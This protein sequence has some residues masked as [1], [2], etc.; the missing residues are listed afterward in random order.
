MPIVGGKYITTGSGDQFIATPFRPDIVLLLFNNNAVQDTWEALPGCL[1]MGFVHKPI[2]PDIS[3][4]DWAQGYPGSISAQEEWSGNSGASSYLWDVAAWMRTGTSTGA[5]LYGLDLSDTGFTLRYSGGFDGGAGNPLYWL[6]IGDEDLNITKTYWDNS[7]ADF[8]CGFE[9]TFLLG[10]GSGSIGGGV[11]SITF[12]DY[13]IATWGLA[14]FNDGPYSENIAHMIADDSTNNFFFQYSGRLSGPKAYFGY[15]DAV[16]IGHS[17]ATTALFTLD[18]SGTH[19]TN[20]MEGPIFG[21]P[22]NYGRI[23]TVIADKLLGFNGG[24]V[25]SDTIGGEV[26]IDT[27]IDIE[28]IVFFGNSPQEN[29]LDTDFRGYL[30]GSS[31]GYVTLD[32]VMAVTAA[33]GRKHSTLGGSTRF[34]SDQYAWVSNF[35]DPL[36]GS[37]CYGTAEILGTSFK[38][39]TASA[40]KYPTYVGF[41]A[42]GIESDA[43]GFFRVL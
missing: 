42:I 12:A 8:D 15:G 34:Q 9:P 36:S 26:I 14:S 39:T 32:G 20:G 23:G 10:A 18:V 30:G 31:F 28:A 43:P 38:V 5:A 35:T 22:A 2:I 41:M 33:G 29:Q 16:N 6:A 7:T 11:A 21:F 40:A 37:G 25:P 19:I 1:G 24:F 3:L 27:P 4:A 13:G 17:I